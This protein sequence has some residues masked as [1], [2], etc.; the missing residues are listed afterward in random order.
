MS[1]I[2]TKSIQLGW[3]LTPTN[4]FTIYQPAT[5]DGTFR[6]ATGNAGSTT[7]VM[8]VSS[9]GSVTYA[10]T[11]SYSGLGFGTGSATAPSIFP[12]GDTNTGLYFPTAE[13]IGFSTNGTERL[14]IDSAGQLIVKG[15]VPIGNGLTVHTSGE[16]PVAMRVS[17]DNLTHR[18]TIMFHK[19]KGTSTSPTAVTNGTILGGLSFGGY[20]SSS[21]TYAFNGGA[22][23]LGIASETWTTTSTATHLSFTTNPAGQ[24]ATYERM[25][26]DPTGDVNIGALHDAGNALRYFDVQNSNNGASA[27][28]IIRLITS[29]VAASG[30]TSVD[31]IKYKVGSFYINNNESNATA[32]TS[33]GVGGAERM[34]IDAAGT[35]TLNQGQIKFPAAQN[36]SSNANTLDDYEEGSGSFSSVLKDGSGSSVATGTN[37]YYY[38]KIGRFV[39]LKFKVAI[40]TPTYASLWRLVG[41]PF[42]NYNADASVGT[43]LGQFNGMAQQVYGSSDYIDV[44]VTDLNGATNNWPYIFGTV[45]YYTAT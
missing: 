10:G 6:I 41:L 39:Y 26:I 30:T 7:D 32:F 38:T 34:R 45:T 16:W 15:T 14:R 5:P 42:T 3:D 8:T 25:R 4:N 13:T 9:T 35:L 11:V 17:S 31:I 44:R 1:L 37:E 2:K 21:Y 20:N 40:A 36:A 22:E 27:G 29:N 12:N 33:F 43:S 28:A 23:I 19:S 24:A 18:N